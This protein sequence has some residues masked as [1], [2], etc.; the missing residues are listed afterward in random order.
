MRPCQASAFCQRPGTQLPSARSAA[1][2]RQRSGP[3]SAASRSPAPPALTSCNTTLAPSETAM[4]TVAAPMPPPPPVTSNVLPSSLTMN[5]GPFPARIGHPQDAQ[6]KRTDLRTL[7]L[8]IAGRWRPGAGG[9]APV[10]NPATEEPV[11]R[12][13]IAGAG[14]LDEALAAARDGFERWSRVLPAERGALL[15]RTARLLRANAKEWARELTA[16]N[17]KTLAESEGEIGRAI[18]HFEWYGAE[19]GRIEGRVA[20]PRQATHQRLIVP[21]PLGVVV[22]FTAWNFPAVLVGR[23]LSAALA[24]GC[25]VI[26]KAAE[27]T[28]TIATRIVGAL[29]EAGLPEGVVNLVFGDP[30]TISGHLLASPIVR[31]L[32]FTGSTSVGRTLARLAADDLKRCTFELGGHAPV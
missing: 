32:T 19:A 11:A 3:S 2:N 10:V 12:H 28:P 31:K 4:R 6:E 16:E 15:E 17:G 1:M 7:D 8:F 9:Y 29:S 5:P 23:K 26:L 22:A 13:A 24:A 21:Q 18:E 27:E 20:T 30:P 14:D 25:A